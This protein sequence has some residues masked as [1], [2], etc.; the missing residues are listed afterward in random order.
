LTRRLLADGYAVGVIL[1]PS[2]DVWR[3]CD[4]L[5]ALHVFSTDLEDLAPVRKQLLDFAP[6]Y[7]VD[8][9][10]RG[11]GNRYRNDLNQMRN[12][13]S[14]LKL[15][16]LLKEA[17]C[18]TFVGFGSHAEYGPCSQAISEST[19]TNP[20]TVYGLTKLCACLRA[21]EFCASNHLRFVWL[22]L[23]S[24][25]GPADDT[26]WLIPYLTLAL[27]KSERPA[28]T[29]GE[30]K[31]DF[32]H[33]RDVVEAIVCVLRNEQA[34]GIFNVGS[35]DAPS[36]R[37]TIEYVRDLVDRS[38]A[39]GFGEIPYRPDQTMVLQADISRLANVAKW[40]PRVSLVEGLCETV[41]W[42]KA[43]HAG[44]AAGV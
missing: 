26:N 20:T 22:R 33:V 11:V 2:S 31:W 6:D 13:R 38:C 29:R 43:R 5:P 30:Q 16:Q 9:A 25:Y 44:I 27:L 36:L 21:R 41:E 8:L 24:C 3:I 32:V 17:K 10:W 1:R 15:L 42:Y 35:G 14:G 19:P 12:L 28:L 37:G 34:T 4:L 7:S 39:L 40:R 18:R 23:F